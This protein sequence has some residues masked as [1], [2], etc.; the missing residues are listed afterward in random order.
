MSILLIRSIFINSNLEESIDMKNY[1][2]TLLLSVISIFS[3]SGQ[4]GIK[5]TG[6][7]TI[8]LNEKIGDFSGIVY[9]ICI[10][11][12]GKT[13]VIPES[14]QICFYDIKSKLLTKRM[15]IGHSKPILALDLSKDEKLLASGGLDGLV[16][17]QNIRTNEILQK[18]DYHHGVITTLNLSPDSKLLATGSSDKTVAIYDLTTG[19]IAFKFSDFTSDITKVKFSP[20]GQILA[21]ASLDQQIRLYESRSG[22]LIA[23]LDGHKNSVRDLCFNVEGNRLFSC[24]DDSRL[25]V[26]DIRN[27]SQIK[28]ERVEN[29]GSDWLLTVE[30][31]SDAYVVAGLDSKISVITNFGTYRGKI[32]V[33]INKILFIPNIEDVLKLVVATRGKGVYLMDTMQFELKQ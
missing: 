5:Q 12:S 25:I 29:F 6:I 21:I 26:W 32:G 16:V 15:S 8:K 19:K 24:G 31:K 20:D 23:G 10:A 22:Q 4:P 7:K 2:F 17:I 28:K 30:V 1:I 18:L 9:D 27:R 3:V 14:N 13:L 33:P 11:D